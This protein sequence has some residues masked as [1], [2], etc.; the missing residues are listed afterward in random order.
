[1]CD[2]S[3]RRQWALTIVRLTLGVIFFA[4]GSAKTF[5]LFGGP[6]LEAFAAWAAGFGIPSFLAYLGALAEFVGGCLLL[7]G[8]ASEL[9]A[10]MTI[11]V[12]IAAVTKIHWAH[13]F[14]AQNG[15]F[16][17]P[18]SLIFFALAIVI[19]GPGYFALWRFCSGYC[20]KVTP[21]E[22]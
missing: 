21:P 1:M 10:L 2:E 20:C 8:I 6:G 4:H 17:Y 12:M 13:G 11:P 22:R 14:F 15:G 3:T 5:G 19:G 7:L 16:E 18:L 9:G